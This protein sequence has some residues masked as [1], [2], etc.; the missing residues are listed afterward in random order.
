MAFVGVTLE[1]LGISVVEVV[2][3]LRVRPDEP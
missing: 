3:G 1:F 2:V